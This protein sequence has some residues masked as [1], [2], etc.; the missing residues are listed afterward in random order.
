MRRADGLYDITRRELFTL[1]GCVGLAVATGCTDGDTGAIETG[2]LGGNGNG[3]PDA[4]TTTPPGDAATMATCGTSAIDVGAPSTFVL[5]KPIYNSTGRFFT[6]RDAGGIYA[7]TARCTHEGAVC[8]ILTG[9]Y[10]CPRHAAL[11]KYDGTIVSGPV[12]KELQHF[13]VCLLANGHVGVDSTKV[14][15]KTVR[16]AA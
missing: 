8:T 14:V 9:Q 15:A 7:L 5:D 6:V 3:Q 2:P 12:S 1:A 13:S 16:L 11:F 10:R 4:S